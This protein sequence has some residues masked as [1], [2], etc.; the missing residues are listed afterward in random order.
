VQHTIAVL[1]VLGVYGA[2]AQPLVVEPYKPVP[3][4]FLLVQQTFAR[5]LLTDNLVLHKTVVS[6]D[7]GLHGALVLNLAPHKVA[8]LVL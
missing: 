7:H 6:G 3:D 2:L 4:Q 5:T 1:M 8:N